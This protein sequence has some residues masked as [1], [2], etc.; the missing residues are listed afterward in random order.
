MISLFLSVC[1]PFCPYNSKT[2]S[3]I[4]LKFGRQIHPG[5]QTYFPK[6]GIICLKSKVRREFFSFSIG[7]IEKSDSTHHIHKS[8][9]CFLIMS[10]CS[11]VTIQM[12]G[13]VT[14]TVILVVL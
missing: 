2:T 5:V 1:A 4:K 10:L 8:I 6:F 13:E 9:F 12:S 11:G 3:S 14:N 7:H